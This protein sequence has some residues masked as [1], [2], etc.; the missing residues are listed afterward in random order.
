VS[1]YLVYAK[2]AGGFSV[3]HG[4]PGIN[5]YCCFGPAIHLMISIA[6]NTHS[7]PLSEK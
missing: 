7:R 1:V 2:V 4:Y 6:G 5:D 3:N